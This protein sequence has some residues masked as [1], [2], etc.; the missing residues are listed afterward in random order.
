MI[1]S[2]TY[3]T[4]ISNIIIC[5]TIDIG[6]GMASEYDLSQYSYNNPRK[7]NEIRRTG[8]MINSINI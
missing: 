2:I 8:N 7:S 3:F 5:L 1:A 6:N 4:V